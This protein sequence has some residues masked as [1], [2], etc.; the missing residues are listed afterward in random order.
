V[1]IAAMSTAAGLRLATLDATPREDLPM[2][3]RDARSDDAGA[4]AAIGRVGFPAVHRPAVPEVVVDKA[5]SRTYGDGALRKCI[6]ACTENPEREFL[7]AESDG[8]VIG[9]VHYEADRPDPEL[10]RIY[11][12]REHLGDGIGTRL[13]EALEGRL[14]PGTSYVL[15][16][17]GTNERAI[18]FYESRGFVRERAVDGPRFFAEHMGIELPSAEYVP[19]YVMRRTLPSRSPSS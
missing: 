3:I 11:V 1:S 18:R 19:A 9:F 2:N 7:V 13:L 17:V 12:D 10:I 16:V 4:I 6:A 8:R 15:L 5:V 14:S